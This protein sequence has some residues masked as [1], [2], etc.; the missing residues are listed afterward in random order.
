[1]TSFSSAAGLN[2]SCYFYE[3]IP[4]V[5]VFVRLP[6]VFKRYTFIIFFLI[7]MSYF[8][9]TYSCFEGQA[10]VSRYLDHNPSTPECE[11]SFLTGE[12]LIGLQYSYTL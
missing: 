5:H 1:M 12:R 4:V 10:F 8:V 11:Q 6:A 3:N 9:L 2:N 7:I